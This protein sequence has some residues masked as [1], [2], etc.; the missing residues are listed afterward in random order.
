MSLGLRVFALGLLALGLV[1]QPVLAS[2]GELHEIAH[3][4]TGTHALTVH[5]DQA[6]DIS[7]D[8]VPQEQ[9]GSVLH[10]LIHAHCCAPSSLAWL[11]AIDLIAGPSSADVVLIPRPQVLSQPL[12]PAPFRPPIAT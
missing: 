4:P 2:L 9:P 7:Q 11:P 6:A 3:D 10:A 1:M 8:E 12:L 5:A